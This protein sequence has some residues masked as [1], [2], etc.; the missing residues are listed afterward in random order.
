MVR[1]LADY[2]TRSDGSGG[3]AR[4]EL[5]KQGAQSRSQNVQN[6]N[7]LGTQVVKTTGDGLSVEVDSGGVA[8]C[9]A[10]EVRMSGVRRR[11]R[12]KHDKSNKVS[13]YFQ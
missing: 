13:V 3:V 10:L 2:D 1:R 4:G 7:Y 11:Y 6:R 8:L 12:I 9:T 5:R